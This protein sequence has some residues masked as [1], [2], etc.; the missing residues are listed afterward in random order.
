MESRN[1]T[2]DPQ[3]TFDKGK[4]E[5]MTVPLDNTLTR[6][7]RIKKIQT[8]AMILLFLAAVINYLDR[9]SL[10]VANLTIREELGL[11]A[12]EIGALLSVFSL[13]YGI[14]QLPCGPLLDRKGPRIMLGLGMFFWSLFQA[15]SGM[16]HSFTQFVLVRIGM[17]IGEAPMNPCGVKVINDWFN[18]KERGRPMGFFNAASTIG[19]AISPPILA[20]M[21]LMMGWR[22]MFIT[23][24][25]LGIFVAIGWYMLYR[26]REDISLTADEQAYLNAG[27]VNVRRDPLSF[28]EWRSLFK[29][30]TMW[31]MMLGFSGINYTAWLY[32]A[33]LP[34][35]LQT[36]YS[37]DLKST[38][39]MA[40]IPF[41]FGA[42]G[43]LINGYVTDWLVK[44]GMAPIKSRKICI[45][46]GMFCSAAFTLIVPQATTSI[47]AVL[48]IGMALFCIH[49]AG[50]SCWG[51]IHVA[52]ASRMTA[53]VGSIQ[54][55]ASF[56][57]A[58][59][60]PVVTGFIVDTTHSFQL[61]LII[62]GCVTALGALAYIF[63]VRQPISDPR[64]G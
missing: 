38:G 25:V 10:S 48:L 40:A 32:L 41:L 37:L 50:T 20:A 4:A 59:F 21:M 52:V 43:M 57:C 19:V 16:V 5:T 11:S 7:T 23:I 17:G 39:F 36:A 45:I 29:N 64:N 13:A 34:G 15:V 3:T 42:A 1:I 8:T 63:L 62:C 31:G 44:G 6:S 28:A 30:K 53:S 60:A 47:A 24:G 18:I 46:A 58:S 54:N 14:A 22:G 12:T 61:A 26:N 27:S 9:S 51:L 49:F 35:Y 56:I 33:W 55:F 2:I